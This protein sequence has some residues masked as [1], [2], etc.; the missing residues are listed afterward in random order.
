MARSPVG[1]VGSYGKLI[2]EHMVR[3]ESAYGV[4]VGHGSDENVFLVGASAGEADEDPFSTMGAVNNFFGGTYS[5]YGGDSFPG[6][7]DVR[8]VGGSMGPAG[9][10]PSVDLFLARL[11]ANALWEIVQK[12]SDKVQSIERLLEGMNKMMLA[13]VPV[14]LLDSR[15]AGKG[16][17]C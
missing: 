5:V 17:T 11:E 4:G 6:W 14:L 10:Q 1:Y 15:V 3:F 7:N 13:I 8:G 2:E 12:L 9:L 16:R